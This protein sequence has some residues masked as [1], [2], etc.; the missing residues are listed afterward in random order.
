MRPGT[1]AF[2][3]PKYTACSGMP[4]ASH[5]AMAASAFCTLNRP[6]MVSRK[7]RENRGVRALKRMSPPDLRTSL[8]YTVAEESVWEKVMTRL[9]F[10]A[11]E[12]TCSF[13][14]VSK[15]TQATLH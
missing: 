2:C 11:A 9:A 12:S 8:P 1:R 15:L 6:G 10:C 4:S 5:T 14:S 7:V 3:R 13:R